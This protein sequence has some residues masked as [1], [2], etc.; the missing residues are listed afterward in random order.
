[1]LSSRVG[2]VPNWLEV[3]RCFA[4]WYYKLGFVEATVRVRYQIGTLTFYQDWN[5]KWS[6][7]KAG[8]GVSYGPVGVKNYLV[9]SGIQGELEHVNA[10]FLARIG[11]QV[12]PPKAVCI[13][14]YLQ[15]NR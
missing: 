4:L 5:I 8:A 15:I 11:L 9:L 3:G 13:F 10:L 12:M 14:R 7:F 2:R 1:M 6:I